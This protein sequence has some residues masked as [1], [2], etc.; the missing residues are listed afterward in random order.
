MKSSEKS[1]F[2]IIYGRRQTVLRNSTSATNV[3]FLTFPNFS[4]LRNEVAL[5]NVLNIR[6]WCGLCNM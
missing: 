1:A 3:A 5:A 6:R 4:L 2:K